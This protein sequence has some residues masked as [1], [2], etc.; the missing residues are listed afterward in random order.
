M[1]AHRNTHSLAAEVVSNPLNF[2]LYEQQ[3]KDAA[4]FKPKILFFLELHRQ[5]FQ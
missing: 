4:H 3:K 1:E 5:K 2:S